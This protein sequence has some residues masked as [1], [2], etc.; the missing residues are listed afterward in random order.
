M[1]VS[2]KEIL[3]LAKL[4]KL[5]FDEERCKEFAG[6]FEEIIAFAD[7]IN[8]SVAGDTS[9]IR[10]VGGRDIPLSELRSDEVKS[11]LPVEKITSNVEAE[12]GYFPV[13]RVVK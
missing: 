2:E 8:S 4:C 10:E 13:R 1:A 9:D 5:E 11:S 6:E 7:T 12:G 3:T